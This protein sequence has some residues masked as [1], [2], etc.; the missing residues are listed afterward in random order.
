MRQPCGKADKGYYDTEWHR[1][2]EMDFTKDSHNLCY[3][4]GSR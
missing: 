1:E 4:A 2:P 3:F